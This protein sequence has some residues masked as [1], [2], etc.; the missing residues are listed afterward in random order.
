MTVSPKK[1][2]ASNDL[3]KQKDTLDI[4]E[5]TSVTAMGEIG[6]GKREAKTAE[7]T[8]FSRYQQLE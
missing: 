6:A 5:N 7:K 3:N 2:E 4:S 1:E 8:S